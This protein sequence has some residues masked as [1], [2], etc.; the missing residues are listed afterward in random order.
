MRSTVECSGLVSRDRLPA[1][2]VRNMILSEPSNV[3][4]KAG[5]AAIRYVATVLE[6]LA[7][8]HSPACYRH[9]YNLLPSS[10][11]SARKSAHQ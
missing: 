7:G 9:A 3:L 6:T 11:K 1:G 2:Y 10:K 8:R 5:I 4:T